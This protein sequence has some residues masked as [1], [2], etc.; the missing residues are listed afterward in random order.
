[1]YCGAVLPKTAWI[2]LQLPVQ[3]R[4]FLAGVTPNNSGGLRVGAAY[5]YL[6]ISSLICLKLLPYLLLI[7]ANWIGFWNSREKL[8]KPRRERNILTSATIFS[9]PFHH[10]QITSQ[11][12]LKTTRLSIIFPVIWQSLP[13]Q[14]SASYGQVLSGIC[15]VGIPTCMP[16]SRATSILSG[17]LPTPGSSK[18]SLLSQSTWEFSTFL[19]FMIIEE[20][21]ELRSWLL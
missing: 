18:F 8:P 2:T 6:V 15:F 5:H 17:D 9:S 14:S 21:M 12:T 11:C 16:Q 4:G 3:L 13:T 7:G 10:S 20:L 19:P 1:M